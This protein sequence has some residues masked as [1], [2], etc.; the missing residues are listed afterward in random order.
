LRT[1]PRLISSGLALGLL[2]AACTGGDTGPKPPRGPAFARG[3]TLRLSLLFW[4][5]HEFELRTEDGRG[6]YALDP[7]AEDLN[8]AW[9]ILR[10]C[11]V[12]TLMSYNG[13]STAEGGALAR[14]DLAAGD[15]TVSADGLTWTFRIRRGIHYAPP[16]ADVEVTA[17][18]FIRALER[19]LSPSLVP[20][21]STTFE[22]INRSFAGLYSIISGADEFQRGD[23]DTISGLE[24]PDQNTLVVHLT[25]PSGDLLNR[26]AMTHTAPIPPRPGDPGAR[27]G[28]ATGH[29]GGW[30]RFLVG[31]GPYMIVGS[32]KL[33]FTRPPQQQRPVAGY[34]PGIS[35]TLV[36][37]PSWKAG[38]DPLRSAYAD[39]IELVADAL[40]EA[41]EAE[42]LDSGR[43]DIGYFTGGTS[44][45][46]NQTIERYAADP[47][48]RKQLFIYPADYQTWMA[49]NMAAPP[50]DDLHVRRAVNLAIDKRAFQQEI[51]GGHIEADPATHL[52]LD[53]LENNL[54]AGYDPYRTNDSG[55]DTDAAKA[56]MRLSGYDRDHDGICDAPAC[57][58]VRMYVSTD[59]PVYPATY[60]DVLRPSLA[61]IGLHLDP[62]R[63]TFDEF[64][65]HVDDP[66]E[67]GAMT[68]FGAFNEFPNGSSFFKRFTSQEGPDHS[69]IGATPRELKAWGYG[70]T[71]VPNV[72]DRY[73]RCL[74][75]ISTAQIRCWAELDQYLMEDVVPWI[76]LAVH[77]R[78]RLVSQRVAHFSYDQLTTLPALDQIALKPGT[79]PAPYPTPSVGPAPDIPDGVYRFTM[80]EKDYR[81]FGVHFPTPDF[82]QE[83][84][85]T[86][87]FTLR[88]GRWASVA[89]AGHRFFAPVNMGT[90]TGSGDGV[91]WRWERPSFNSIAIPPMT[92]SLDATALTFRLVS[93]GDLRTLDPDF[94]GLCDFFRAFF[95]AHPWVRVA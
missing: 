65:P 62:H 88:G 71:N 64:S 63:L 72:T 46:R 89:V 24:A 54:L 67:F 53:S 90:Y 25:Q 52:A 36:R 86:M 74:A 51:L 21:S 44:G 16:L 18:D 23:A 38:L 11:L 34:I 2:A 48:L 76:P 73:E 33:D 59:D 69:L 1:A 45:V 37:N 56:E 7:H 47:K 83:N 22:P 9:E 85:G 26:F 15:P 61:S 19:G 82:L 32:D 13:R 27:F 84:T 31:T 4:A 6:E 70:V 50:F 91:V 42:D 12:R 29:E 41:R 81:R 30:G 78:Q 43:I 55:G 14:P 79:D 17:G 92:W 39:R 60:V 93:C 66:K 68:L 40:D 87:T 49:L 8:V 35:I 5:N 95:Q 77:N 28:V 58:S 10:C 20:R 3:G 80:T 94:P 57:A 75:E